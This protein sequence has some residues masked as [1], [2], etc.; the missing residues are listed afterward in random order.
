MNEA[1][2]DMSKIVLQARGLNKRYTE[3]RLDVHV[4]HGV[5][6]QVHAGETWPS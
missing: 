2:S 6:L 4:L 5:D 3:G 1:M